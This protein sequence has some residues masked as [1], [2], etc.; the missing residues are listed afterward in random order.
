MN[1]RILNQLKNHSNRTF[2]SLNIEL[3]EVLSRDYQ[4]LLETAVERMEQEY[5]TSSA[6]INEAQQAFTTFIQKMYLHR[7]E[8]R[9]QKD[10][11]RLQ[12]LNE[13]RSSICPLWPIC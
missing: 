7:E 8:R 5:R 13:S 3:S 6:D 2:D 10:L 12:A 4:Q 1:E 11:V 9:G